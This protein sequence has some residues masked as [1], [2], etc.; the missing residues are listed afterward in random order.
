MT[1]GTSPATCRLLSYALLETWNRRSGRVMTLAGYQAAG[2]VH[3]AISRTAERVFD[4]L[5]QQ[6]LGDVAR[7][8]FLS[9]VE[10]ADEGR[11]TRRREQLRALAPEDRPVARGQGAAGVSGPRRPAGHSGREMRSRS[12]MRR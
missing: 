1:W 4:D 12:A 3:D 2:G 5:T 11:A 9:L 10:P 6:G 7:R 8:I